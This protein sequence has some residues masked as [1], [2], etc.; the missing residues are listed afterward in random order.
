MELG[1]A[2]DIAQSLRQKI[3]SEEIQSGTRL[4]SERDIAEE[5]HTSR[6]TVRRALEILEGEGLITRHPSRGSFVGGTRE[7]ILVDK[8]REISNAVTAS[9]LRLSGSFI[10]DMERLGRKPQVQFLEQPSLVAAD[11]Q[12]AEQLKI[13]EGDLVFKRYRLQI[14]DNLPYRLIESYYPSDLF[15]ELLTINI[16]DKPLFQWLQERH[17]IKVTHAKEN[18]IARLATPSERQLLKISPSAPIVAVDRTVQT[19]VN[20][21]VEFAHIIAVAALYIFTYDYD[22]TEW[23]GEKKA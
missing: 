9:E 14:A 4:N 23:N 7:R 21:P 13:K 1:K 20:R 6:M 19:N 15:G 2:E 3:M 11:T 16:G 8:G 22:I 17:K 10:K 18:L 5:Y 12:I